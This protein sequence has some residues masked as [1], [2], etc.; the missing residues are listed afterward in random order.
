MTRFSERVPGKLAIA[1][2]KKDP[3]FN[4]TSISHYLVAPHDKKD[5]LTLPDFLS[6]NECYSSTL[7]VNTEFNP[8]QS[9][10][11]V[12]SSHKDTAFGPFYTKQSLSSSSLEGYENVTRKKS[13]RPL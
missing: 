8:P 13:Q 1:Y 11:I 2:V 3:R 6:E 5:L 12:G 7:L 4:S 10:L 9:A